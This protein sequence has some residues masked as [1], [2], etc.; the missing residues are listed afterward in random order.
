ME[1]TVFIRGNA[2]RPRIN[3]MFDTHGPWLLGEIRLDQL[4]SVEVVR[5]AST[6]TTTEKSSGTITNEISIGRAIVGGIVGGGVAAVVGATGGRQKV[7]TESVAQQKVNAHV[8]VDLT[9]SDRPSIKAIVHDEE[10]FQL[11][12]SQIGQEEWSPYQIKKAKLEADRCEKRK[13]QK[14]INSDPDDYVQRKSIL[15]GR[16]VFAGSIALS[17]VFLYWKIGEVERPFLFSFA[18][19]IAPIVAGRSAKAISYF[20]MT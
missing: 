1:V 11:L 8:Y 6:V 16:V 19:L 3:R 4:K 14:S 12:Q 9:F 7:S 10:A 15:I 18:L 5:D 20:L 13:F 17:A 2:V